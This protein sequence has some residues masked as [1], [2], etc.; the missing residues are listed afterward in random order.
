VVQATSQRLARFTYIGWP[1]P[2]IQLD[3]ANLGGPGY[4]G[5]SARSS[6]WPR[7]PQLL[8]RSTPAGSVQKSSRTGPACPSLC[9]VTYVSS[10]SLFGQGCQAVACCR[11]AL[12]LR[13]AFHVYTRC[14]STPPPV[15][16]ACCAACHY[17]GTWVSGRES[18]CW[19]RLR[20][21]RVASGPKFAAELTRSV[22][23]PGRPGT[24]RCALLIGWTAPRE[25]RVRAP[26][27]DVYR[28][29][30]SQASKQAIREPS[31][32]VDC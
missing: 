6:M 10:L 18:R 8:A 31:V 1:G 20:S 30:L 11:P 9:G 15:G 4:S 23:G 28:A 22:T 14:F 24:C 27:I 12:C 19:S 29:C 16:H 2:E 3:W 25:R 13:A 32:C 21:K 5:R 17:T 7:P 26:L